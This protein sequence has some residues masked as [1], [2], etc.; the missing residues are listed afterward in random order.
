MPRN[1][2]SYSFAAI[3]GCERA[4]MQRAGVIPVPWWKP[5]MRI[6]GSVLLLVGLAALG[7]LALAVLGGA[8]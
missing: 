7:W 3:Y 1:G 8:R 2:S 6:A 4:F 5:V